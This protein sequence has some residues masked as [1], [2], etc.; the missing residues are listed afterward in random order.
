MKSSLIRALCAII[1]GALLIAYRE[2]T[3]TW[4]TMALGVLFLISGAV[5]CASYIASRRRKD[6]P[7]LFDAEGRQIS[8]TKPSFPIVGIGSIVLGIILVA[9]PNTFVAWLMYILAAVL[10]LG[11]LGQFVSLT[12]ATRYASVGIFFWV[13][14]TLILL[15][16]LIALVKPSAVASAP[17]LVIGWC[18]VV[19]GVTETI[20]AIKI[21][22]LR[23]AWEKTAK[24]ELPNNAV[25]TTNIIDVTEETEN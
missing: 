1:M 8:G 22:K 6:E 11:A 15:I 12:S 19:Y 17:L 9:I 4:L 7:Q 10:I 13:L 2:Q 16:A 23:K 5:S 24:T 3:I 14:P 20:N 18:M 25:D 21:F